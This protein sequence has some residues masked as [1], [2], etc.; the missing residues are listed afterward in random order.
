MKIGLTIGVVQAIISNFK[1]IAKHP[2]ELFTSINYKLITFIVGYPTIYR[3][4]EHNKHAK[5]FI[6]INCSLVCFAVDI[7][8]AHPSSRPRQPTDEYHQWISGWHPVLHVP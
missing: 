1:A 4:T 6:K 2:L 5:T 8:L 7:L 3:V